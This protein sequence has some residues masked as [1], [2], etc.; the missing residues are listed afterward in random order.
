MSNVAVALLWPTVQ[1]FM[2]PFDSDIDPRPRSTERAFFLLWPLCLLQSPTRSRDALRAGL[3]EA[4]A[5]LDTAQAALEAAK[6]KVSQA[7][8]EVKVTEAC[9]EVAR[10]EVRPAVR[11]ADGGH[12][13]VGGRV[14]NRRRQR[15]TP[16]G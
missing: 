12:Q 4:E 11:L 14:L 8:A 3:Q 5:K 16:C 7:Q 6:A 2:A 9:R 10:A 1:R 15:F 13:V